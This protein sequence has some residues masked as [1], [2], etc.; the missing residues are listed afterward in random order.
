MPRNLEMPYVADKLR[1]STKGLCMSGGAVGADYHWGIYAKKA[2]YEVIHWSFDGHIAKGD[3]EDVWK[4]SDSDLKV[5]DRY[6][7]KANETLK[8]KFPTN[9]EMV[10]NLLRRNFYQVNYSGSLYAIAS[11]DKNGLVCSGTAWAVQMYL[12]FFDGAPCNAYL[13]CQEVRDW[14]K[15]DGGWFWLPKPPK[16]QRVFAGIGSRILTNA[17]S[18]AIKQCLATDTEK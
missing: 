13:Y 9:N 5:A 14:F 3:P 18:N 2:G 16:P 12:D 7:I 17:G 8:R 15:W 11:L 4:L 6:L 1:K 10:N